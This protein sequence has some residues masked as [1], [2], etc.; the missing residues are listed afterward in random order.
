MPF[1]GRTQAELADL[2]EA[3]GLTAVLDGVHATFVST[4]QA[5]G[6]GAVPLAVGGRLPLSSTVTGWCL[7]TNL[8]EPVASQALAAVENDMRQ[9]GSDPVQLRRRL[10]A[11]DPRLARSHGT[12]KADFLG[13]AT[14][15]KSGRDIFALTLIGTV[16]AGIDEDSAA[17][18]LL[19]TAHRITD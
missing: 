11:T 15:V 8:R 14:P 9:R 19:R 13:L 4:A 7:L 5:R 3:T 2:T 16:A 18:Q 1:I 12:W 10:A 17:A 6:A